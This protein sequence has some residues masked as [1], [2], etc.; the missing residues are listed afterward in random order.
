LGHLLF[1]SSFPFLCVLIFGSHHGCNV[2]AQ[3]FDAGM[4]RGREDI[5]ASISL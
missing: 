5:V 4:C 2:G 3:M 1:L